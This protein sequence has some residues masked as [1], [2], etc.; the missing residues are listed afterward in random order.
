MKSN[1]N[2]P[3]SPDNDVAFDTPNVQV[4]VLSSD[5]E[6]YYI[7]NSQGKQHDP[8]PNDHDL[9]AA[10]IVNFS[11]TVNVPAHDANG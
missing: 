6:N 8:D 10:R 4:P 2:I 3:P 9:A 1:V 7:I 11:R 5:L